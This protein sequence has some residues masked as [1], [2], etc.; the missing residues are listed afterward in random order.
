MRAKS[1]I[2]LAAAAV[3]N[4]CST[5]WPPLPGNEMDVAVPARASD[6]W[7]LRV[8]IPSTGA[9][10]ILLPAAT[11]AGVSTWRTA[12]GVTV[13]LT[14]GIVVATR[15]LGHDLMTADVR[16]TGAAMQ[17]T[18]AQDYARRMRYLNSDAKDVF[19]SFTCSMRQGSS[20]GNGQRLL[21]ETCHS[22]TASFTN[23]YWFDSTDRVQRSRQWISPEVGYL[24]SSWV[25]EAN[26]RATAPGQP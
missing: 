24:D 11:N 23:N 1:V 3:L 8:D 12:D 17:G 6:A 21:Q 2:L 26:L 13:S 25:R 9:A 19:L 4:A 7:F 22:D 10:A 14:D 15:G 18:T 16:G 5:E 20:G